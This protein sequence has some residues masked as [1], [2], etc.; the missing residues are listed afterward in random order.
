[1]ELDWRRKEW[2]LLCN[3]HRLSVSPDEKDMEIES[4]DDCTTLCLISLN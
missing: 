4:G 1:M 2:E 3:G